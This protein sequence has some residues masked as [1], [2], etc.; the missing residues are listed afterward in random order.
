MTIVTL[1]NED[2]KI[3]SYDLKNICPWSFLKN[4]FIKKYLYC[5]LYR[6]TKFFQSP[7]TDR[8]RCC[9]LS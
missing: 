7:L 1:N 4:I 5:Y 9:G 6:I 8:P 2:R 3:K